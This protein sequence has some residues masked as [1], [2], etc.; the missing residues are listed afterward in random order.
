MSAVTTGRQTTALLEARAVRAGYGR[1]IV[2]RDVSVAV[3]QGRVIALIGP[4]GAGKT[5]LVRVL[6][7]LLRPVSGSILLGG[8]DATQD[9]AFKRARRG[10]RLVPEG[11]GI[12]RDLTVLDNLYVQ[13]A[14]AQRRDAVERLATAFPALRDRL[15]QKAGSLSGGQQQMLALA[16]CY[17]SDPR[18]ILVDEV[19]M[20]LAPLVV[21]QIYESLQEL[22]AQGVALLIVEQYIDRVLGIAEDVHILSQGQVAFSGTPADL[23]RGYV[24][25]HY[26]GIEKQ[27]PV[28]GDVAVPESTGSATATETPSAHKD[29]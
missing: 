24:M 6:A 17:L 26:L 7:G 8:E 2:L 4:N 27:Q 23:D 28:P 25:E 16:R 10:L 15:G 1:T 3:P 14:R 11:R 19:S 20:G 12:F 18:L 5:T 22:A 9:Q 13:V 21:D 29:A